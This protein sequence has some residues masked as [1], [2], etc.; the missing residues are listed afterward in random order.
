VAIPAWAEAL[1]RGRPYSSR[2][3][4]FD[5]ASALAQQWDENAL[6]LALSAHPRIGEKP[7]G[8][9]A[10]AALSRQEQ[11]LTKATRLAR[12]CGKAMPATRPALGAC[13]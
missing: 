3:A 8:T 10:E 13:F 2:D 1:V 4:L 7:A 11:G 6:T 9:Q 5:A 12:H